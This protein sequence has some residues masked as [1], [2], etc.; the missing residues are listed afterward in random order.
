MLSQFLLPR[1]WV[2]YLL[3]LAQ[4][5]RISSLPNGT[6]LRAVTL[7]SSVA[8]Q[9]RASPL[10]TLLCLRERTLLI[11]SP[12]PGL[13][14][15]MLLLVPFPIVPDVLCSPGCLHLPPGEEKREHWQPRVDKTCSPKL[16]AGKL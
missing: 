4:A 13:A 12:F 10:K 15:S 16:P 5:E 3:S 8:E 9:W 1:T 14:L 7:M 11:H 6:E 2:H